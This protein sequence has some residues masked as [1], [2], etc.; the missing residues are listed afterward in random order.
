MEKLKGFKSIKGKITCLSGLSIGGTDSA[1]HIGGIDK[2]IIRNPVTKQ[3]FIP[4]SSLKGKMRSL[5]E[6]VLGKVES[7]GSPHKYIS[8]CPKEKCPICLLFGSAAGSGNELGPGRLIFR[9]ALLTKDSA[10][11]LEK[12]GK[13]EGLNYTEM[14]TEV[15]INRWSAKS[16]GLRTMER[17]PAGAEFDLT[18]DIR[19]FE[20]DDESQVLNWI[21]QGLFLI[22]NDALGGSGS[23]G[24]GRVVFEGLK[25]DGNAF[26]LEESQEEGK[27]E[28]ASD[29]IPA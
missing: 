29:P 10:D 23:R 2:Y 20:D 16:V 25:V 15:S 19:L 24:Y 18:L 13:K 21:K 8:A 12:V 11:L 1:I 7:D 4:G 5:L 17:V 27:V 26:S 22:Q 28:D 6:V 9:D 14:K 3:P